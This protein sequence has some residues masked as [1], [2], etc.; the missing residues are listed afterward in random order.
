M[1]S[2]SERHVF[3]QSELD[4]LALAALV[5]SELKD[6]GVTLRCH[7]IARI[8]A[9][10][11]QKLRPN[12]ID[13]FVIDGVY[14]A[15]EHSW[16]RLETGNILDPYCIGRLP[17]V[18]LISRDVPGLTLS[19]LYKPRDQRLDIDWKLIERLAR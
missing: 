6:P 13:T 19:A 14:G 12:R 10:R 11:L 16:L 3:R 5:V 1:K 4:D 17:M 18:Q 8:V 15:C 9:V 2:Y 7:E